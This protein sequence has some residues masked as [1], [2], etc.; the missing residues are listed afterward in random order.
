[1]VLA[2]LIGAFPHQF[3]QSMGQVGQQDLGPLGD[4]VLRRSHIAP[5][6]RICPRLQYP[7][8]TIWNDLFCLYS[9]LDEFL[10]G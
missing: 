3:R 5:L 2:R 1:M 4:L 8:Y 6:E 9:K 7:E 10:G